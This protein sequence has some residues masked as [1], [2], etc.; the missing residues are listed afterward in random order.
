MRFKL[1]FFVAL[2]LCLLSAPAQALDL[3]S[4]ALADAAHPTDVVR[5]VP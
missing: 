5:T 2:W 4:H 3:P 1:W